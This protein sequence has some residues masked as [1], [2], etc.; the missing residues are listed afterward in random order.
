MIDDSV[1]FHLGKWFS[2]FGLV[3]FGC[4][5]HRGHESGSDEVTITVLGTN[6]LHGQ[7]KR[8]PTFAGYVEAIREKNEGHVVLVDGGD[9][10]Q[11]TLESNSNEGRSVVEIYNAIG[12]DAV[13]I[14]NHEFDFGPQGKNVVASSGQDPR[15]AL[16]ARAQE[17][18]FPF[19]AATIWKDGRPVNWPNV[20]QSTIIQKGAVK[21][22]LIGVTTEST[23]RTTI[24]KNVEDLQFLPLAKTIEKEALS[25]REKG[26]EMIVVAAHAGGRCKDWKSPL[27]LSSCD[28]GEIFPVARKLPKGLVQVIVAGHTHAGVA[29]FVN[30]IAIVESLSGGKAFGR[31]DVTL[32]KGEKPALRILPPT[33]VCPKTGCS[34]VLYNGEKI[35]PVQSVEKIVNRWEEEASSTKQRILGPVVKKRL[36]KSRL[37]ESELGN[38]LAD[39]MLLAKPDHHISMTNGGGIRADLPAGDLRYGQLFEVLPFDNRFATVHLTGEH[40][41]KLVENNLRSKSGIFSFGGV[42]VRA[43]CESKNLKIEAH[44][45]KKRKHKIQAKDA[46]TLL[47]SDFLAWG[48]DGAIGTLNLPDGAIRIHDDG[49]IR[50][51]IAAVLKNIKSVSLADAPVG[52]FSYPGKRPVY[53][54]N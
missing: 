47:T 38:A 11:G 41:Y 9:M 26:A 49:P 53:C 5:G 50:E 12:Y 10:F 13:T 25:L 45:V 33:F 28:G 51:G 31:V 4:G 44:L 19:L 48:G 7:M 46:L 52:R 30:G 15:G 1:V 32:K 27:D 34:N 23:P 42:E 39:W 37:E 14:G 22:G 35:A 6:D 54:S 20:K 24:S 36:R 2:L 3:C 21:I 16:R 8:L 17:A 18:N 40:F 43:W 29:H